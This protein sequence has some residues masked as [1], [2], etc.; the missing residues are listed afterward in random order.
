MQF[1]FLPQL[2]PLVTCNASIKNFGLVW[3]IHVFCL[4]S[5]LCAYLAKRCNIIWRCFYLLSPLRQF[6]KFLHEILRLIDFE[7]ISKR[8]FGCFKPLQVQIFTKNAKICNPIHQA[9]LRYLM[10]GKTIQE[11]CVKSVA[12]M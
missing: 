5:I 6:V 3:K 9:M 12:A 10:I 4:H 8:R 2:L 1:F 11:Q 7:C